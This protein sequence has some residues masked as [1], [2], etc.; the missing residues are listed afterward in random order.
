MSKLLNGVQVT[1]PGRLN[2][3]AIATEDY[4]DAAISALSS[5]SVGEIDG[6]GTDVDF[7]ITHNAGTK[8]VIVCVRDLADDT[9]V[10]PTIKTP[11]ND[12][13]TVSFAVAPATGAH[14]RVVVCRT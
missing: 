8:D 12:T 13:I 2:G 14:Y 3:K 9:L 7:T 5:H 10:T 11:T 1:G 6:N 4:V